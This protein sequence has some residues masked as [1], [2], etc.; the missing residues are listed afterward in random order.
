MS[1][2]QPVPATEWSGTRKRSGII[3]CSK[4]AYRKLEKLHRVGAA[5]LDPVR[6][7]Y[8]GAVNPLR[9]FSDILERPVDREHH[10][11]RAHDRNGVDQRSRVEITGG[12]KME[13]FAEV[14][15][16]PVLGWIFVRSIHPAIAVV[17]APEIDGNAFAYVA[18]HNLQI[19]TFIK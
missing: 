14:M 6:L 10:T 15:S 1:R 13:M 7:A 5:N 2:F 8:I 17:D 9:T 12:R 3:A 4:L 19:R 16:H 18:K 11:V